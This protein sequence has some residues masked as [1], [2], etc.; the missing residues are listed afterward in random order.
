MLILGQT[1][2]I[3]GKP[4]QLQGDT[5]VIEASGPITVHL[6]RVLHSLMHKN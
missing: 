1:V 2:R 4:V 6:N 5:A 3:I